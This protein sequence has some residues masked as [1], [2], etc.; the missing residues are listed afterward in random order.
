MN[1]KNLRIDSKL[2]QAELAERSGISQGYLSSLERGEKQ[3]TLPIL[4]RLAEALGISTA[5]LIDDDNKPRK[6]G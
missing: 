5:A 4:K 6:A 2:S 1:L 3:P